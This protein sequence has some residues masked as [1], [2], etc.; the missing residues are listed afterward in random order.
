MASSDDM[1]DLPDDIK[2]YFHRDNRI[3]KDQCRRL[4]RLARLIAKYEI[5]GLDM[6]SIV[7]IFIKCVT[8]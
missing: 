2:I 3:S 5:D 8:G 4:V 7:A 1:D 6:A